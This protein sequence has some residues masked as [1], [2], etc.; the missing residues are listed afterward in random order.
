MSTEKYLAL[1][2]PFDK[3]DVIKR[4]IESMWNIQNDRVSASGFLLIPMRPMLM[5]SNTIF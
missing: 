1:F 2:F 3:L 5:A 4:G